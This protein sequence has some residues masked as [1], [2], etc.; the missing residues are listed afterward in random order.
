MKI[1]S[2]LPLKALFV[3]LILLLGLTPLGLIPLGF[4]NVTILVLPVVVGTLLMGLKTGLLLGFFFGTVSLMSVLG[5][6]MSPPSLLAG[7]LFAKS[8][9]LCAVMCYV[10]RLLVP[11]CAFLAGRAFRGRVW[12]MALAAALASLSNTV[13][14]LGLMAAFY[15]ATGLDAAKIVRLLLGTG[16]IAGSMEA[17]T[18]ALLCPPIVKALKKI[19]KAD[20]V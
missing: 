15:R 3:A 11:V 16:L 13:L 5:L 12:G 9:L 7:T 20:S 14:Y 8:P 17:L 2:T 6:G 10:P 19:A 18:A 4:I 1:K